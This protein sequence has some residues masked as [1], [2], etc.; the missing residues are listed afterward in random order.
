MP[1]KLYYFDIRGRAEGVRFIL[2][3]AG[4]D[5]E[6][7]RVERS[8][9]PA[10]KATMPMGQMPMLEIDG[11]KLCQ[12]VAIGR[13]LARKHHLTGSDDFT[14]AQCDMYVDGVQDLIPKL[15]PAI[16]AFFGGDK[17]KAKEELDNFMKETGP[18]FLKT[19]EK[20]LADNGT[21][22][23]VGKEVTWADLWVGEML[24]RLSEPGWI[25]TLL[26]SYPHL[27]ALVDKVH[28]LPKIKAWVAKRPTTGF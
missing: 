2:A 21:G 20:F 16:G 13:F 10:L 26:D 6:D 24:A 1:A 8:D 3:Q 27:K 23:L 9:W 18:N 22:W 5:Y 4:V 19:Y 17:A 28:A 15:H 14:A 11:H 7:V 12:S 25:P